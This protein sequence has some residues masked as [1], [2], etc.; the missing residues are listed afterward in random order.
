MID[1]QTRPLKH[2]DKKNINSSVVE[3]GAEEPAE[4]RG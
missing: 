1:F 3:L 2:E 4:A